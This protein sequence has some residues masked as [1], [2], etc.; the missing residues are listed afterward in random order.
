MKDLDLAFNFLGFYGQPDHEGLQELGRAIG[1]LRQ[2]RT[3]DL[4][5]N[6]IGVASTN[7]EP[8]GLYR[9]M[10]GISFLEHLYFLGLA[11]NSIKEWPLRN[12][13]GGTSH[14]IFSRLQGLD[15][16]D[17]ND[18]DLTLYILPILDDVSRLQSLRSLNIRGRGVI[19]DPTQV[20]GLDYTAIKPTKIRGLEYI[21]ISSHGFGY[22]PWQAVQWIGSW[23]STQDT[24]R[25]LNVS[26]NALCHNMTA[27]ASF[28]EL[29]GNLVELRTLDFASNALATQD[30]GDS[31]V[32]FA[33]ASSLARL[34]SLLDLD[35]SYNDI[36]TRARYPSASLAELELAIRG[37]SSLYTVVLYP[38]AS[39]S[40]TPDSKFWEQM[41]RVVRELPRSPAINPVYIGDTTAIDRYLNRFFSFQTHFDLSG[42]LKMISGRPDAPVLVAYLFEELATFEELN[43]LDLSNNAIVGVMT[44]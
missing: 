15:T 11:S 19:P 31:K 25:T 12:P 20:V 42:M 41:E 1:E 34:R 29:I 39:E 38:P 32:V 22:M 43:S 37:M 10:Q 4:S 18:N 36:A 44:T 40:S 13:N 21:D 27:G 2:L 5:H 6:Y 8:M 14:Y 9:I 16:L 30:E 28:T 3:L 23:L 7:K 33:F 35:I 26:R 17:L 24:A